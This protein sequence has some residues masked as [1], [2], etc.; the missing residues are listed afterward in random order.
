M[1]DNPEPEEGFIDTLFNKIAWRY[2]I[3]NSLMSFGLDRRWR[4]LAVKHAKMKKGGYA[5]DICCGTGMLTKVLASVGGKSGKVIGLDLSKNMIEVAQERMK[6][7]PLKE[8]VR[9]MQGNAMQLPFED[10]TFDCVTV[11]WGLRNVSNLHRVLREMTRV[12]KPGGM[13]VSLDMAKP[14]APIFSKIYWFYLRNIVPLIGKVVV[15]E[16]EAYVY[17]YESARLFLSA[18]ELTLAF[19][20]AGLTNCNY[21]PIMGGVVAIVQGEKGR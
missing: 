1:E 6:E 15:G 19:A 21:N 4:A 10:N 13:V 16:G 9:F 7:F 20:D 5:L 12:V 14:T 8:N 3:V 18:P 2:D 11:G 17:L